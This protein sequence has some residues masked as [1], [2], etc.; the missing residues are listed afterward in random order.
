M[1]VLDSKRLTAE[2]FHSLD[3]GGAY[4]DLVRGK[5]VKKEQPFTS[6]GYFTANVA[7]HL[8][9]FVRQ[10]DIGR[11]G[12]AGAGVVTER[13]PDTVRG[14][15]V[16]FYSYQRI[17]RGP[18]PQGYWPIAPELVIEIRSIDDRWEDIID[19][20]AEYL[21]AG[22]LTVAVVDPEAL[23][24][25]LFATDRV[26]LIINRD[27]ELTFPDILPGFAIQVGKLFE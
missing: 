19:Q 20:A 27:E 4:C 7:F 13:D 12:G 21:A 23:R 26:A 2:E 22:V 6:H 5:I 14:P 17:P 16:T 25:H 1:T 9:Q 18:L 8:L 10:H 15:D 24:V 3:D 11:V